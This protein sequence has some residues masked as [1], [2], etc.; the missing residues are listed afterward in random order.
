M[1]YHKVSVKTELYEV[2]VNIVTRT[3]GECSD[4]FKV[5]RTNN[6]TVTKMIMEC[7]W[8]YCWLP[9]C[10]RDPERSLPGHL[11]IRRTFF[12]VPW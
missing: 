10:S 9:Q 12:M 5:T 4:Y 6:P 1:V 2:M 8:K 3:L 11:N 7:S